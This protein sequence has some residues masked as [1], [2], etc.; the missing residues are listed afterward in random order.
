MKRCYSAA[1]SFV[2][3]MVFVGAARHAARCV[4]SF[5]F[6]DAVVRQHPRRVPIFFGMDHGPVTVAND[7][8][9]TTTTTRLF[10]TPFPENLY[11]EWT[12]EQ[13]R[14]LW[15][16]RD[17]PPSEL[18]VL[19]GRGVR[20]VEKR[21]EKLKDVDSAAYQR[22]FVG[23]NDKGDDSKVE[24]EEWS[25][26]SK[27]NK[28]LV[29]SSEVLR[30]IEWDYQL[31][32]REFRIMHY[33]RVENTIVTSPLTAPNESITSGETSLIKALPEHRIVA[34][35]YKERV[36]WDRRKNRKYDIF[37]GHPGILEVAETY[38]VWKEQKDTQQKE[39]KQLR[40][41]WQERWV[42]LLSG[43]KIETDHLLSLTEELLA[44]DTYDESSKSSAYQKLD[45][46][47]STLTLTNDQQQNLDAYIHKVFELFRAVQNDRTLA[48]DSDSNMDRAKNG[49]LVSLYDELSEWIASPC[50]SSFDYDDVEDDET[51]IDSNSNRLRET[52]L[53]KL[54]STMDKLE[55][56]KTRQS[57]QQQ[58]LKS[59]RQMAKQQ[60]QH[61]QKLKQLILND[62]DIEETF[63]R[64]SGAGGQKINKTSNRVVLVH[65][66][67]GVRV[68]C[69]ETRS[70]QQNRK[71]GR[72][73]LLE[74][75][76]LHY[77]GAA[78]KEQQKTQKLS[79]K[80]KKTKSKNKAR[81]AAKQE[82]KR[83][84]K[85]MRAKQLE[86]EEDEY[87]F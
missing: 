8:V 81:L 35:L 77:H 57:P 54:S 83:K 41:A 39:Q 72:K 17:K 45:E 76:D 68:E 82:A 87:P 36:V 85:A 24:T 6:R 86:E 30:R 22:L 61:N 73:R 38:E 66:P 28:K 63:V 53:R 58:S 1:D 84:K 65:L 56:K 75:L 46:G 79:N 62:K 47:A 29:P 43:S 3:I 12:L 71:I 11:R 51:G 16:N 5:S 19:L 64:G 15:S 20:G 18:G 49:V 34:I 52:L 78:S 14:L 67:S 21:I 23:Q 9:T 37:F 31:E 55:G 44:G 42:T 69:Q 26:R 70:L 4:R 48:D 27:G 60:N 74:K 80:K 59:K 10:Y 32:E 40:L 25:D 33:D 2:A 13:D 7:Y 50:W